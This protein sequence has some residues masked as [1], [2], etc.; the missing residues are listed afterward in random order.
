MHAKVNISATPHRLA[1]SQLPEK[2]GAGKRACQDHRLRGAA[3]QHHLQ[4]QSHF[5][6]QTCQ[7]MKSITF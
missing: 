6:S 3:S 7:G 1:E 4:A 5:R 2:D